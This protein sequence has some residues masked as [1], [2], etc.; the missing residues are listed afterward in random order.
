M[1]LAEATSLL[2]F[3]N[4][5]KVATVALPIDT[6]GTLHI[7]TMHYVHMLDP[8]RLYFITRIE[9]EKCRL[10]KTGAELPAACNV[11]TYVETTFTLQMRGTAKML[12][13]DAPENS[14][15][16]EAYFSKRK[17][18]NRNIV[19]PQSVLIAFT[20]DWARYTEFA[21]GWGTTLLELT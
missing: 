9:S 13:K 1:K 18:L 4:A 11:G 8:L 17:D 16:Q 3:L 19:G 5:E 2:E 14:T 21:K 10:L 20:P 12:D 7:A 15:A 6:K